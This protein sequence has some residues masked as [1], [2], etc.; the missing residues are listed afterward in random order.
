MVVDWLDKELAHIKSYKPYKRP[1]KFHDITLKVGQIWKDLG[2]N[3]KE[4]YEKLLIQM[5]KYLIC[6][7]CNN[8]LN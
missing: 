4:S 2:H 1:E 5:Q 6:I 8:W 3:N 7:L